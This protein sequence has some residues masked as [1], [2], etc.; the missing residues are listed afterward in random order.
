MSDSKSLDKPLDCQ[1][2]PNFLEKATAVVGS[3]GV[4]AASW[5][6]IN[7][8][9]PSADVLDNAISEVD[10]KVIE[11][12]QSRTVSWEG[13]PVF[14]VH[15]TPAQILPCRHRRG[16]ATRRKTQPARISRNGWWWLVCARIWVAFPRGTMTA[17][18][19]PVMAVLT[20]TAAVSSH[21]P[22]PK[23]LQVP[24]YKIVS[25]EKIIIGVALS[26]RGIHYGKRYHFLD[27][28]AL[29]AHQ[30]CQE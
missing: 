16:A 3:V 14:I 24:P 25:Q 30:F 2:R 18:C 22:A 21:G 8:M 17:G 6:F 20:T 27:R 15:R 9:N 28:P 4:A 5:P 19:A 10:L 29:S 1:E 26:R 11:I 23:N 13:K 12:G 7:S